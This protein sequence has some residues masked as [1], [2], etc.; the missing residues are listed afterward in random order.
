MYPACGEESM[1]GLFLPSKRILFRRMKGLSRGGGG[2]AALCKKEHF[3]PTLF[4]ATNV[5]INPSITKCLLK[6]K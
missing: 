5:R 4:K 3:I 1:E 2:G 6:R